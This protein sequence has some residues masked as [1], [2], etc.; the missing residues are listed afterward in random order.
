MKINRRDNRW[1]DYLQGV[2]HLGA[3]MHRTPGFKFVRLHIRILENHIECND[4]QEVAEDKK[5]QFFPNQEVGLKYGESIKL[6]EIKIYPNSS[7][8]LEL[9]WHI[10]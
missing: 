3:G 2:M 4:T 7:K 6:N 5:K 8:I 1:F 9:D 10:L